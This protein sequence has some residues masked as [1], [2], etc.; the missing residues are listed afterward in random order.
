MI[1][2]LKS[3]PGSSRKNKTGTWRT[4][5]KP[6]F[7]KANCIGCKMCLLVCPEGCI[8]GDKKNTYKCDYDYCKGCGNCVA[9]C[10][11]QDIIMV[12]EEEKI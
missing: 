2:H 9:I 1:K 4:G 12:S 6:K 5:T 3:N 10:P 7:L 11:K 8:T